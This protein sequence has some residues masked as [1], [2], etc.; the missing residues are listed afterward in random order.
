[1]T[2]EGREIEDLRSMIAGVDNRILDAIA[3]RMKLSVEI[4]RL[5]SIRGMGVE[6]KEVEE[7]VVSRG[8]S[9]A[10]ELGLDQ[11]LAEEVLRL[12]IEYSKREQW[13]SR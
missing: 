6:A 8:R 7:Q 3:D 13:R 9:R 12:L 5:K 4:G 11:E 10:G 1:M 2:G